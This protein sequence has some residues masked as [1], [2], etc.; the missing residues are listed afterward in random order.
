VE[1]NFKLAGNTPVSV[2]EYNI[3]LLGGLLSAY[4][5]SGRR[6]L[7]E[8]ARLVGDLLVEAFQQDDPIPQVE[9][10]PTNSDAGKDQTEHTDNGTQPQ[11][12][13]G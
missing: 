3:R 1:H 7:L 11:S 6:E 9:L 5:L 12:T 13:S 8:K 10:F 2:F 4:D